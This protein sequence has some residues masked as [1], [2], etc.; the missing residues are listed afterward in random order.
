M[1]NL[2]TPD[3]ALGFICK[4]EGFRPSWSED[5][6]GVPTIGFGFTPNT[7]CI[8]TERINVPLTKPEAKKI[9][10]RCVRNYYEPGILSHIRSGV[11]LAD[12][13]VGALV[14]FAWNVGLPSF[15]NSTL[16]DH[17]NAG[18][19]RKA[20]QEFRKWKYVD[21]EPV[22]GLRRRRTAERKM[23]TGQLPGAHRIEATAI[24]TARPERL[25]TGRR[26]PRT[27]L[28]KM[29]GVES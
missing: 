16:L 26:W 10:V 23:F 15:I 13:Q 27:Q 11:H 14:S 25:E 3:T 17:I 12:H 18:A 19:T 6:G 2:R 20:V 8:N 21:G 1:E 28:E 24:P 4:W 5:I 22:H 9:L 7:P 29:K